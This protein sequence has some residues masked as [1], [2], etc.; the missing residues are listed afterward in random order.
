ML[1]G[2]HSCWKQRF[3]FHK[4]SEKEGLKPGQISGVCGV[5]LVLNGA[6]LGMASS[7]SID[8][9]VSDG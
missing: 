7:T 2:T 4:T 9:E 6:T 8:S 5:L 1:L 3:P